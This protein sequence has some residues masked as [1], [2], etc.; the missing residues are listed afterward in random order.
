[1]MRKG[2]CLA[3]LLITA[4][5]AMA[6][7]NAYGFETSGEYFEI[8]SEEA[9]AFL[10]DGTTVMAGTDGEMILGAPRRHKDHRYERHNSRNCAE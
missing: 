6:P 5:L 4:A 2:K 1:M 9:G 8:S 7:V 10:Y 3:A